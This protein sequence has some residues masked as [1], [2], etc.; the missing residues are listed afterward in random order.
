MFIVVVAR[1]T[2]HVHSQIKGV[3]VVIISF[4][5]IIKREDVKVRVSSV[6]LFVIVQLTR[7][8]C[9][10]RRSSAPSASRCTA[11]S[12]RRFCGG[13]PVGICVEVLALR[14]GGSP[15][16]HGLS[17]HDICPTGTSCGRASLDPA[18]PRVSG[19]HTINGRRR[20]GRALSKGCR[21]HVD[22]LLRHHPSQAHHA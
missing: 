11:C 12:A 8:F 21:P 18:A 17:G 5:F 16:V 19:G 9:A 7:D 22:D 4:S 3:L 6:G 1:R 14:V 2:A 15:R 13:A 10:V 20:R